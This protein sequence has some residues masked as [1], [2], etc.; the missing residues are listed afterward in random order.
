MLH[1]DPLLERSRQIVVAREEH[2]GHGLKHTEKVAVDAGAII[3]NET[4]RQ[5]FEPER[6]SRIMLLVHLASMFHDVCRRMRDHAQNGALVAEE[7]LADFPLQDRERVWIVQ[8]IRNHEAF[9]EP[10]PLDCHEGQMISDA[11]YDADKFRWGPD[12]FTDT[13]W[14][15]ISNEDIPIQLILTHFPKGMAGIR[16]IAGTFRSVTGKQYGPEYIEIG[17]AI[18]NRLY[19]ELVRKFPSQT[20]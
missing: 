5:R 15:M 20:S 10:T 18:G 12:N 1:A 6:V 16:K 3:Q 4:A 17:L 2:F 13:L 9:T 7:I 14:D 8:A 19:E 11:L